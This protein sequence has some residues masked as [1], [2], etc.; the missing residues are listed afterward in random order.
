MISPCHH[1][2]LWGEITNTC[3]IWMIRSA[4]SLETRYRKV[5]TGP[6][7][8]LVSRSRS[9]TRRAKLSIDQTQTR[10]SE[11]SLAPPRGQ[12]ACC[13]GGPP[14]LAVPRGSGQWARAGG[15]RGGHGDAGPRGR[16]RRAAH[17]GVGGAAPRPRLLRPAPAPRRLRLRTLLR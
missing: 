7:C 8:P 4:S 13:G 15:A 3:S 10:A 1:F 12:F 14:A 16:R 5:Q 2:P 17:G 9:R 11:P 6:R